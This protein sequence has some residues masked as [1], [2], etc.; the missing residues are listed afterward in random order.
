MKYYDR[1]N[2]QP[3]RRSLHTS[4]QSTTK[5]LREL[6]RVLRERVFDSS[7]KLGEGVRGEGKIVD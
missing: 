4:E 7:S 5:S 2:P 1:N 3:N 6:L